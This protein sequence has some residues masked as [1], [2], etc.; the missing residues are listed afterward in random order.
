MVVLLLQGYD[1]VGS[2]L[3]SATV[4]YEESGWYDGQVRNRVEEEPASLGSHGTG[5]SRSLLAFISCTLSSPL[6]QHSEQ[7]AKSCCQSLLS[8]PAPAVHL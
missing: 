8:C 1:H 3:L 2:R 6:S 5:A 7:H 4:V